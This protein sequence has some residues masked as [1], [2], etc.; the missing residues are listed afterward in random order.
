[1]VSVYFG[2]DTTAILNIDDNFNLMYEEEWFDDPF[3]KEMV[4]DI[5]DS[6]VVSRHCIESPILGQIAPERLSGG[7]KACICMWCMG[8]ECPIIDLIVCGENC[9]PWLSKIFEKRNVSVSMSGYD[10][11][12]ED[13][14]IKGICENDNEPINNWEDWSNKMV[15]YVGEPENER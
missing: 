14:P 10:L 13:L 5:D 7:V 1:M 15:D 6:I 9:Q 12:F 4:K 3:V 8:E 2:N 11:L